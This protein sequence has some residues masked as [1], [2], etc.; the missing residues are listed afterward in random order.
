MSES[1]ALPYMTE[2]EYLNFENS[3]NRRHEYLDGQVFA[4]TGST[5]AHNLICVNLLS[6]LHAHLQ[7]SRCRCFIND[8]KVHVKAARSFYYPDLMVTCESF[9]A[10]SVLV[11]SPV[12]IIEV[13]SPST[14]QIDRR[15]K[16]VAYR[17][18]D[19]LQEYVLVHQR[20]MLVEI[21]RRS[22][23]DNWHL[24]KLSSSD[25]LLLESMPEKVLSI[26]VPEIYGGMDLPTLVKEGEQPDYDFEEADED[27]LE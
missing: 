11:T 14:Q 8:V 21:Y 1:A 26:P 12:L 18:I 22:T 6:R 7:G 3:S 20:K 27:L 4:M 10:S 13:L 17:K 25:A 9:A 23:Q 24:F 5:Q 2:D 16:L 15:E 19:S